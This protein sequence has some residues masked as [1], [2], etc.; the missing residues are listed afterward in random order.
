MG[1]REIAP[2]CLKKKIRIERPEA[3]EISVLNPKFVVAI[4]HAVGGKKRR[5]N[6]LHKKKLF[7]SLRVQNSNSLVTQ[8]AV[9]DH[10]ILSHKEEGKKDKG[11]ERRQQQ[12]E[13]ERQQQ[14][15]QQ[16]F[17]S[18][19]ALSPSL[20]LW[21]GEREIENHSAKMTAAIQEW[22]RENTRTEGV[23]F[24]VCETT[25]SYVGWECMIIDVSKASQILYKFYLYKAAKIGKFLHRI[26]KPK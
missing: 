8:W 9:A 15:Q 23:L 20:L 17:P 4:I 13:R 25:A 6:R 11:P 19:F 3:Q 18:V 2:I 16:L 21:E 7:L 5:G 24:C 14:Q 12:R 1:L 10:Q 26:S 22:G